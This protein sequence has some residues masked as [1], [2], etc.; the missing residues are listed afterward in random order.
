MK[1]RLNLQSPRC[2][3]KSL[4]RVAVIALAVLCLIGTLPAAPDA[5]RQNQTP[6]RTPDKTYGVSSAPIKMEV[7][8]DY[9]C[10]HCREFYDE[11][12]RH[13]IDEYV[14]SGKVYLVHHD[15]PLVGHKYSGEAARWAD[16]CAEVGEFGPAE[17]ALYD[18]QDAWGADGNIAK[19]I[20][21]AMPAPQFRRVAAIVNG[22]TLP[23]PQATGA[24]LDPMAGISHPC[25]MDRYIA[26]DIKLGYKIAAPGTPAFVVTYKG[27]AFAP[28]YFAVSWPVLKQLFDSLLKQ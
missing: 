3:A 12:L 19:Y 24:S 8:S 13:V 10:P 14:S 1:C 20:A 5:A 2:N 23:A 22:S 15:F 7:F 16:A 9:Q 21:A 17:A 26:E 25:A 6:S 28:V 18:N 4:T 27:H 11:T